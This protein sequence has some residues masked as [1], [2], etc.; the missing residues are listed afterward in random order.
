MAQP[1]KPEFPKAVPSMFNLK[2]AYG[3]GSHLISYI[4]IYEEV[5]G[6]VDWLAKKAIN[7]SLVFTLYYNPPT[8]ILADLMYDFMGF[9]KPR[10]ILQELIY[11]LLPKKK[12]RKEMYVLVGK[13]CQCFNKK[14]VYSFAKVIG[15][16]H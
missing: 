3:G 9:S 5:N 15:I 2:E 16:F 11:S 4:Y 14:F 13:Y 6:V 10:R 8:G 1:D 7:S 12:R